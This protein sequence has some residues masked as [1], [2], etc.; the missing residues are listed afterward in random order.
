[1]DDFSTPDKTNIFGIAPS[2]ANFI[3]PGKRPMS[4]MTPSI[5][6]NGANNVALLIGSAGG[7]R[8][9]TSIAYV[10]SFTKAN[11]NTRIYCISIT[12]SDSPSLAER[13]SPRSHRYEASA[14]SIAANGHHPRK[15]FQCDQTEKVAVIRP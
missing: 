7:S 9:T 14:S 2:K 12:E 15:R 13:Y 10:S 4:S 3:K 5:V 6:L 1:M 8:I 11:R